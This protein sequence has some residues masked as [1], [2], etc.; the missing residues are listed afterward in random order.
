MKTLCHPLAVELFDR[1]HDPIGKYTE[2]N[3]GLLESALNQP[4]QTF[5]GT[6]LYLTLPA[7]AA[8]LYYGLNKNHP[9]ENGNKR[10]SVTALFTF[11]Y[12]NGYVLEVSDDELVTRTLHIARSTAKEREGILNEVELWIENNISPRK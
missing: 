6:D 11:L 9:F 12:I 5:G 3:V 8:V 2:A 10:I 4:R 7:K 1:E